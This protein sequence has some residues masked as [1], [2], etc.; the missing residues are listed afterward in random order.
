MVLLT[1]A[2]PLIWQVID[3]RPKTSLFHKSNTSQGFR[4]MQAC[5]YL[6]AAMS[7]IFPFLVYNELLGLFNF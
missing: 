3:N 5:L 1:I 6:A 2:N 7:V 4:K